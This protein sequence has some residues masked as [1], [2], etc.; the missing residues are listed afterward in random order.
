MINDINFS[1]QEFVNALWFMEFIEN[2]YNQNIEING[3]QIITD[4]I[5]YYCNNVKNFKDLNNLK[6]I[7]LLINRG[8]KEFEPPL[9]IIK[10]WLIIFINSIPI[11]FSDE[12]H[13]IIEDLISFVKQKF[14]GNKDLLEYC[15][16]AYKNRIKSQIF[17]TEEKSNIPKAVPSY[18]P[19]ASPYYCPMESSDGLQVGTIKKLETNTSSLNKTEPKKLSFGV[20][21]EITDSFDVQS[22]KT[23]MI[24]IF[25][26]CGIN[27]I[28][29]QRKVIDGLIN[30][31]LSPFDIVE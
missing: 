3:I 5:E 10:N 15:E 23:L 17:N 14:P 27:N 6:K 11:N 12:Y 30:V 25:M 18:I 4:I 19:K 26:E 13:K 21:V 1:I 28:P 29:I 2:E 20:T 9:S 7:S 8:L 22:M 31:G 24:D 16:K